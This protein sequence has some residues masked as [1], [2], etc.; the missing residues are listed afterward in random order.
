MVMDPN[1]HIME[2]KALACDIRPGRRPRG[3]ARLELVAEYRRRAGID[4][5]TGQEV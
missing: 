3:P 2:T 1:S 5:H 4:E